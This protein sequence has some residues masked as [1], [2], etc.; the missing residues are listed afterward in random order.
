MPTGRY[1]V[2]LD[3]GGMSFQKTIART[4]DHPNVYEVS[5]PV[6]NAVTGWT[7]TDANTASCTLAGGHGQTNGKF[8]VYWVES[9]VNKN[10]FGVDGTITTNTLALDGGT[11]DDFPATGHT[12]VVCTKQVSINVTLDGDNSEI[13]GIVASAADE[14]ATDQAH[15]DFQDG[16]GATIA[17]I[18]LVANEPRVWDIGGG[19]TNPFTGNII[20][21]AKASNGSSTNVLTLK[22]MSGED[23]T[24]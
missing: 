24:P 6:G 12:G 2:S 9:G 8:D 13:V 19:S 7:K 10:R 23:S 16:A 22:I 4:F 14:D 17:D 1:S 3:L 18:D 5:L 21:V 20:E 15:I 11:G